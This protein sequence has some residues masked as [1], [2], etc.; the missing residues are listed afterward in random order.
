M[1]HMKSIIV[2]LDISFETFEILGSTQKDPVPA[3]M[4]ELHVD[5]NEVTNDCGFENVYP[6]SNK[7][8]RRNDG[9][10]YYDTSVYT[11]GDSEVLL[12]INIRSANHK[13][14][15]NLQVKN[16][17]RKDL[18]KKDLKNIQ[19][20][21]PNLSDPDI[22]VIDTYYEQRDWGVQ[23]YI[24]KGD[25]YS[26]PVDSLDKLNVIL[27]GQLEKLKSKYT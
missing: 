25:E 20:V 14:K 27:K 17:K 5:V 23:Y 13:S 18:L 16:A 1:H 15:P 10:A 2:R 8:S 21:Y 22:A 9:W 24:G 19:Q 26:E 11:H 3:I 4:K 12:T 6:L 7:P